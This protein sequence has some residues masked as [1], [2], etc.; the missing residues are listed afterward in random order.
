VCGPRYLATVLRLGAVLIAPAIAAI[1]YL[2]VYGREQRVA[3][4]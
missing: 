4:S 2:P 3:K 1:P